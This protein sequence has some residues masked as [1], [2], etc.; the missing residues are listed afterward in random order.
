MISI[1]VPFY[2]YDFHVENM[3]QSILK[4]TDKNYEVI[5]VGNNISR[6]L[7]QSIVE[8]VESSFDHEGRF[9]FFYTDVKNANTARKYGFDCSKG[10][11]VFFLDSDDLLYEDDLLFEIDKV[12]TNNTPDIIT[13]NMQRGKYDSGLFLYGDKVFDYV[14]PGEILLKHQNLH[15]ILRNFGTNIVGRFI[16]R[17]L[18]ENV[19]FKEVP[20]FQDWNISAKIYAQAN[21]FYFCDRPSYIWINRSTSIS[22][23][24]TTTL[25]SYK[26]AFVSLTDMVEHYTE[27]DLIKDNKLFFTLRL[28]DFCFQYAARGF[29]TGFNEGIIVSRNFLRKHL[30]FQRELLFYPKFLGRLLLIYNSILFR[31]Y[32]SQ[33]VK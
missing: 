19:H 12:I 23:Y 26:K 14:L 29:R 9:K 8:K 30:Y 6:D 18:L 11:Y 21:R 17:Q 10:E 3:L 24:S 7:Y 31:W 27:N 20:F 28:I 5:L 16:K 22:Q 13:V 15:D 4:Q 25:E 33:K 32:V 2:F 1:I